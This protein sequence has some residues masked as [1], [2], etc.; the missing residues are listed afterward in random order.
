M[1]VIKRVVF[2]VSLTVGMSALSIAAHAEDKGVIGISLPDKTESRWLTDGKSMVDALK[3]KG[4]TADLQYA[5]YDVP[6]QVNQVE[7]MLAK[8]VKALVI[9]PIDGKTFS[10]ALAYAQKKHIKVI[11]YDRL[12][13]QTKDVDYYATFDNY[14]VGVLQAQSIVQEWQKKGSKTP[15]NIEVFGGSSD[16]NNAHMIYAG[17]MS[18]LKP[19]LDSGKFVI[20]SKQVAF[21]KVATRNW[22]GATAQSRM[23]NLLSAFY[24]KDRLDAVWTPND[25]IAIGVISSLK[26]VGYGSA[27]SP[28]PVV[29]G[30]DA[31]IQNVKAIVRGDQTTTVFKDTRKLASVTADMVDDA[32]T[33]KTVPVNDTKS[34]NNGAKVVPTY[35]V[36]PV[37]VD[38][39]AV[40]PLLVNSGYYTAA[41]IK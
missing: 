19:Y 9:A 38:K 28:M 34:Y 40:Q 6:T 36:K 27:Q 12:I 30:Q 13:S 21:E 35:L 29:T 4:Y 26:G 8:G 1:N 14:G 25:A 7:N 22:D 33:G 2:A 5:N 41:Q 37:L 16:D 11:S 20:R 15:Y 18:V 24:G 23:D 39:D 31:D 10:D 32:L 17:G 3:A